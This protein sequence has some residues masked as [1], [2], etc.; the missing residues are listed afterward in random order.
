MPRWSK[1]FED[2]FRAAGEMRSDEHP[3]KTFLVTRAY[4]PQNDEERQELEEFSVIAS[5]MALMIHVAEADDIV[6]P[7]EKERIIADMTFQLHQRGHEYRKLAPEFGVTDKRIIGSLFDKLLGQYESGRM[8]LDETVEI[9]NRIFQHNPYSRFFLIR[10]CY[11]CALADGQFDERE[12][13]DIDDLATRLY[14][15]REQQERIAG[16]V[17]VELKSRA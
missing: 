5:A 16:E 1:G 2:N 17:R 7:A 6:K 14:V 3:L 10:L 8:Q 9:V 13:A 4:V 12:K 15:D 11:Y